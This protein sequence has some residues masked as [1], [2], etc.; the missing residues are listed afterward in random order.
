M[1]IT[2]NRATKIIIYILCVF[3]FQEVFFRFFF[4]VP[5]IKNFDSINFTYLYFDGRGSVH[6]RDQIREWQS[7]LDTSTVFKHQ[8][9][10]YGFR[11]KEW[12]I[13]KDKNKKRVLFIGDSFVEGVMAEQ[14]ETIPFAFENASNA[15][16]EAFNGG[17]VGCGLDSYL[18]LSADMIPLYKP[19]VA[20]L[21]I[22]ANDL[23]QKTPR[24]P[25]FYLE[26]EYFKPYIPR[27]YEIIT[28]I[29]TFGPLNFR[30]KNDSKPY[31]FAVPDKNNPWTNSEEI[32]KDD[33]TPSLAE[34]MKKALFN[35]FLV[36]ALAKEEKY[37]KT[38]PAIGQAI[39]FFNYVCSQNG[40]K[41]VIIYIP[42]RNQVTD[43]Y[44]PFEKQY[45]LKNC[46]D[47]ISLNTPEY[48]IHQQFIKKQ[49]ESLQIQFMDLTTTVK[50]KEAKGE[51]LYWNYDQHM[52]AEGYQL[53]GQTIWERLN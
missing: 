17:M 1:N 34:N 4:P 30:W 43:Y 53:L 11:D 38:E 2:F 16:Y 48:Q 5:E 15:T 23:G 20:F 42:S 8:M 13:E 32:L 52:R 35:P 22:Y 37:L 40:T 41:P 12:L 46:P 18:Q 45:C 19:E 31:L 50:E 21:C 44:L 47:S 36:N 27:L 3:V 28:Q 6:S 7:I 29:K 51:H 33:V 26:P 24:I 9:N 10:H 49:C 25:E 14:N 39:G